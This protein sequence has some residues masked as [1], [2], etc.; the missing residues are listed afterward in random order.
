MTV[1]CAAVIGFVGPLLLPAR[2]GERA[3]AQ[4]TAYCR[5]GHEYAFIANCCDQHADAVAK[6]MRR[7]RWCEICFWSDGR[8]WAWS[9]GMTERAEL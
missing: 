9:R 6:R 3:T 4:V 5:H 8:R 1:R 2:C 7:R